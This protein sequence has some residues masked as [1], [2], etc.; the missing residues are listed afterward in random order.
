MNEIDLQI[1]GG[2]VKRYSNN[3]YFNKNLSTSERKIARDL[4]KSY[5]IKLVL[6]I[7]L[8]ILFR[9]ILWLIFLFLILLSRC[10][11]C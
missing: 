1:G 2:K 5:L 8:S 10:F 3:F 9:K 6:Y 7:F 11:S 4:L